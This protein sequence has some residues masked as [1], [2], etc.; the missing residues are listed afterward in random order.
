LESANWHYFK[1]Q[2]KTCFTIQ[3]K[4]TTEV[5]QKNVYVTHIRKVKDA[6]TGK[7]LAFK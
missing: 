1:R 2:G 3:N 7:M 5:V 6:A 4:K